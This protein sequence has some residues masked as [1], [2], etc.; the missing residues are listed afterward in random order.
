M[1][2]FVASALALAALAGSAAA[3]THTITFNNRW[4]MLRTLAAGQKSDHNILTAAVTVLYVAVSRT[5][6]ISHTNDP[7][8]QPTLIQNGN[9]LSTGGAYTHNG[10]ITAAIA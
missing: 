7:V 5:T 6:I 10:P 8:L 2:K 4:V 1:F 3:E 9:V